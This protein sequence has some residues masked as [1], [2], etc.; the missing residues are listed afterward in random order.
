MKKKHII[1]KLLTEVHTYRCTDEEYMLLRSQAQKCGLSLSR[2]VVETG[3]KHHPRQR[4]TPEECHALD[5]LMTARQD[6]VNVSNALKD[7]TDAEKLRMFKSEKFM[8]WWIMAVT[9]LIQRWQRI[10]ENITSSVQTRDNQGK[11]TAP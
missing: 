11:E 10:E 2:Y 8:N 3:L 4:L 5:S 7:K 9:R 6:L 1:R